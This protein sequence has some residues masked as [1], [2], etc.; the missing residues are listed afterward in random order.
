[1]GQSN[2]AAA[3]QKN[4]SHVLQ[5]RETTVAYLFL[6]PALLFFAAFVIVPKWI[7][8]DK[9]N[10]VATVTALPVREDVDLPIEEHLIVELYSK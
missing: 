2:P 6:L 10:L 7:D 1:M 5:R 3:P 8:F 9:N 4:L